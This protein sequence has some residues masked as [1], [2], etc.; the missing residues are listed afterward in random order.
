MVFADDTRFPDHLSA[1][2]GL[3]QTGKDV[4]VPDHDAPWIAGDKDPSRRLSPC[5]QQR[6]EPFRRFLPAIVLP[7]ADVIALGRE[8]NGIHILAGH[9]RSCLPKDIGA[10]VVSGVSRGVP[11]V[12]AVLI[13]LNFAAHSGAFAEHLYV[14]ALVGPAVIVMGMLIEIPLLIVL[15]RIQLKRTSGR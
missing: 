10:M 7:D 6:L 4:I 15:K 12:F 1:A 2:I 5:A 13:V 3:A 8:D 14:V 9:R 11:F